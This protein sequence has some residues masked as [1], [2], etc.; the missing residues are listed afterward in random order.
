MKKTLIL[1]ISML[2]LLTACNQTV[3]KGSNEDEKWKPERPIEMIAPARAGGGWDTS[4]RM[5]SNVIME[6]DFMDGQSIGVINKPG[7]TGAVGWS[8][9]QNVNDPHNIFTTSTSMVFSM[10]AGNSEYA[11]DDMTPIANLAADYGVLA[12]RAD[13]PWDDLTELMDD[14]KD[15]PGNFTVAGTNTPGGFDH[16]QFISLAMEAGIPLE[17]VSYVTDQ[18]SGGLPLLLNGTVDVISS[19][20]GGGIIEQERAGEIKIL[21]ILA[22]ERLESE[23][24]SQF[25]TAV[26]QGYDTV[27]VNWRGVYGPSGMTKAQVAY[28]EDILKQVSESEQFA[29]IRNQ[30]GWDEMFMGSEEFTDFIREEVKSNSKIM[31]EIGLLN[32]S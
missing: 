28:Y 12:V 7:G 31:E 5:I 19:K 27:F 3:T 16:V 8:Y 29:E 1:M 24:V 11:W 22:E 30:L 26:E 23:A 20:L 9:I 4:A 18:S 10:L 15:N 25:P 14:F 17:K 32:Q 13:A 2:V 21:A 6:Q